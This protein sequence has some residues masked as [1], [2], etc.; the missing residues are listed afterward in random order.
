LI[1]LEGGFSLEKKSVGKGKSGGGKTKSNR[2]WG[3]SEKELLGMRSLGGISGKK[4]KR[5]TRA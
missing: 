2:D 4:K 5:K 3:G 1:G